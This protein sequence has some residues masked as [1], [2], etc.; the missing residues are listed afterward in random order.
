MWTLSSAIPPDFG[1]G[2]VFLSVLVTQLGVPVP[3]A[4]VLALA[5]TMAADGE[6]SWLHLLIAAV[7]ATLLA[8][9]LWFAAGRM[10]GRRLLNGLVRFS[11]S[12]DTSVRVARNVFE[13]HGAPILSVTKFVPGFGL[14]S[15]PLLGTTSIDV[16]VFLLWDAVGAALWAGTWLFGGAALNAEIARFMLFVHTNGGTIFDVLATA[17]VL[18]IAYR[19]IRR[20]Q[21]RRWLANHRITPDQLDEMMRSSAPP[22]V[23]DAR[24]QDVREKEAYRIPGA[25][26]L[27]LDSREA[28]APELLA[29]P[30]V[31][32]CVCPNEASAKRVVDQLRSKRIYHAHALKGG[33]DAWVRSGYPVEPLAADFYG[34]RARDDETL[35]A[36][37]D[38]A[39]EVCADPSK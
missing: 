25:R 14:I 8:D 19:W 1:A 16:R 38:A 21:F 4:P 37:A 31:V 26:A 34:A 33:L 30:I 15:A 7:I 10:H 2:V 13:R 6:V 3:A 5:G 23:L 35:E 24:P 22:H 28:L 39:F 18:F 29:R 11:L 32:Y 20:V 9:S 17:G 27:N 12:L 36:G